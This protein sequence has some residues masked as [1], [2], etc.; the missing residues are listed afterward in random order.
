MMEQIMKRT[1]ST[2]G[3]E[4]TNIDVFISVLNRNNIELL[5]DVR[6]LPL[7]RK[8]GF[9]KN[10]LATELQEHGIKYVHLKGLGDPKP[11]RLAARSGNYK[12]FTKIFNN[13]LKT[14][15]AIKDLEAACK[16]VEAYNSCLM[17]FECEH[18]KCHRSIVANAMTKK[19]SLTIQPLMCTD[20][21][22]NYSQTKQ[23]SYNARTEWN[24]RS[25][26]TC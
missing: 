4:G 25:H 5:I 21:T 22:L 3:Y 13:H 23:Q 17:C 19:L 12:L 16:L 7:S 2:I 15:I 9:S 1:M 18:E 6:D 11:G 14:D 24:I 10:S 8:K 20:N 26:S